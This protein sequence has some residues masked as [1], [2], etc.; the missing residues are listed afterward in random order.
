MWA[1]LLNEEINSN[2]QLLE[3]AECIGV[4]DSCLYQELAKGTLKKEIEKL[5]KEKEEEWF[6][7]IKE[8]LNKEE[9]SVLKRMDDELWLIDQLYLCFEK[10]RKNKKL[11]M[12]YQCDSLQQMREIFQITVFYL[13]R[14]ELNMEEEF[15]A[16]FYHFIKEWNLS[17]EFIAMV[18]KNREF[19]NKINVGKK[20]A[21]IMQEYGEIEFG[22]ELV[23]DIKGL[24]E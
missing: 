12:I 23:K 14:I 17:S 19:C 4:Q 11:S 7:K 9:Y 15:Y 22:E 13:T 3:F 8:L 20:L 16:N 1:P 18:I 6:Y 21:R 2:Q 5:I 10:E 24:E